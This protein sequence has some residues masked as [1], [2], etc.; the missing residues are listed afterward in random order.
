MNFLFPTLKEQL[1][2]RRPIYQLAEQI[3]WEEFEEAF[4]KYYSEEG[5]P[6]KPIRLMVGLLILKQLNNL[7]DETVVEKWVENP[8][9]QFFC[10]EKQMQWALP[11]EPSDLV[12][13]RNRIGDGGMKKI[14]EVSV[15]LHGKKSKEKEVVI[16]T[17]VQE[18]NITYPTDT[19]LYHKVIKRCWKIADQSQMQL[20]RRYRKQVRGCLLA[21]RGR[22]NHKTYKKAVK[23]T[24]R[25]RTIGGILIRELERKLPVQILQEYQPDLNLY[26]RVLSQQRKDSDKIYS[27]HEPHVYCV[28]KGKEHKKYE[29][30]TKASLVMTKTH[31]IIVGALA[32]KENQYDGHSLKDTLNELV[33]KTPALA[34]VDRGY[35][36]KKKVD[37][38]QILMAGSKPKGWSSDR[39]KMRLRRRCAI[40]PVISHLKSDFRLARNYLKAFKGDCRNLLLAAAAWNFKKW[41]RQ[42]A[43]FYLFF[44]S[45]LRKSFFLSQNLKYSF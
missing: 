14:L 44:L 42:A 18:K 24:R 21:Q 10:G 8:Y 27:L 37:Q 38:T 39:L 15:K 4:G 34:I 20:R 36:G 32:L 41:L 22:Q 16:D 35:R 43:S 29:F 30:G 9:W 11:C 7:G 5:R 40:E 25:L 13:F 3:K 28:A 45:A 1:D 12:H 6:A 33:V 17:T 31:G 19:K 26:A 2:R 23:A